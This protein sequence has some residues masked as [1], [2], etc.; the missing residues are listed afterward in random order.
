[1]NERT[2][3]TKTA[4]Q[5]HFAKVARYKVAGI[6]KKFQLGFFPS[7]SWLVR[8]QCHYGVV[9]PFSKNKHIFHSVDLKTIIIK[10]PFCVL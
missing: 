8:S 4:L 10:D 5:M 2:E 7:V 6:K 1:M 3:C 9:D